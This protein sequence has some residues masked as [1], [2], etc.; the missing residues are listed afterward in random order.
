M[1]EYDIASIVISTIAL[2]ISFVPI[3]VSIFKFFKNRLSTKTLQI[4]LTNLKNDGGWNTDW[5]NGDLIITNKT[6]KEFTITRIIV[7]VNG[8]YCK[9]W[10]PREKFIS[11]NLRVPI[12]TISPIRLLSHDAA[13]IDFFIEAPFRIEIPTIAV[14][15]LVTP[16]QKLNYQIT[17]PIQNGED[18]GNNK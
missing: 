7:I 12:T 2:V 3:I 17:L 14:L 1:S 16:Y 18:N 6:K 9:V 15:S 13:I 10:Q 5:L 8:Q 4:N 11:E